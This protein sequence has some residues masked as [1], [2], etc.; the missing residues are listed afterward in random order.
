MSDTQTVV[1][2]QTEQGK[3]TNSIETS[4]GHKMIADE[5][6]SVGGDD[7][8]P[9]PYDF[10]LSALGACK[11][12]TM[13]M[14]ANR[15]GYNLDHVEVKL[16]HSKIHATDCENCETK[17]G[18]VDHIQT[19]ITIEGDLTDEERQKIF[20]IAARCPVH[21]TITSEIIINSS[22]R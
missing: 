21:R 4:S 9:P 17:K 18:L 10:L 19:D 7:L 8:G 3:Y 2:S 6:L 1:V 16:S 15:K 13:R 12:M 20:D 5:P 14:Y 11:S 22:L